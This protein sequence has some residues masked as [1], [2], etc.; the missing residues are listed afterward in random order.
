MKKGFLFF[1]CLISCGRDP[2]YITSH[3]I[4]VFCD[5]GVCYDKEEVEVATDIIIDELA[6]Q[7]PDIFTR[8]KCL[9]ALEDTFSPAL[10][11][12]KVLYDVP[13]SCPTA[14]EPM[15]ECKG[16]KCEGYADRW[17]AGQTFLQDWNMPEMKIAAYDLECL[18]N[19][20]LEHEFIHF[21]QGIVQHKID[22]DHAWEP[23]WSNA[24]TEEK[25][26]VPADKL[27]CQ[28][29]AVTVINKKTLCD[30]VC[31]YGC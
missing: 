11:F 17:C 4:Y 9:K 26:P 1:V 3:G 12:K 27:V 24:C 23:Y 25:Y 16:F 8:Q 2:E 29:S 5:E 19:S 18:A 22:Y 10:Y 28:Q 7:A 21:F 14:T 13:G 15:K 20:A 30:S 6:L 31:I